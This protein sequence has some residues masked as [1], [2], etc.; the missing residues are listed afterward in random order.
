MSTRY[1]N[2]ERIPRI[3]YLWKSVENIKKCVRRIYDLCVMREENCIL[4]FFISAN[5]ADCVLRIWKPLV[6]SD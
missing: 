2:E 5:C 6:E 4:D 1:K 3:G